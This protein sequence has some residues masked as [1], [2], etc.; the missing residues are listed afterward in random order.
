M[1]KRAI[2]LAGG[3]GTRL[4]PYTISLPKPLVPINDKPI[5]ELI[6]NQLK[7]YGF[8]EI[9]ICVN[10]MAEMIKAYFNDGRSFGVNINYVIEPVELS[11]MGP[12]TLI[13]DL[14]DDFIVMNGDV[15]TDI[16]F[17]NLFNSHLEN[18]NLFTV[19]GYKRLERIDYGV[20]NVNNKNDLIG[21]KEKPNYD[22]I[23]S[24]G[25]YVLNKAVINFIPK[26][27]F[28]GFDSLMIKMINSENNPSVI[29]HDGYWLD[30]G[31]PDDYQKAIRDYELGMVR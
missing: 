27:T 28:F 8:T 18:D 20:L 30:I 15:L 9:T 11:T 4:R 31:R 5:L 17:R 26:N 19:A 12:L 10:H 25:V 23:V 14:P 6:V 22:F 29:L 16:N 3:K 21:F 24:M 7:D 2:I 1:C 13:D